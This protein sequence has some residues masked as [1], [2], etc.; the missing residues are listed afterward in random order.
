MTILSGRE[1]R[2][3]SFGRVALK[4]LTVDMTVG[5]TKLL[6]GKAFLIFFYSFTVSVVLWKSNCK[7]GGFSFFSHLLFC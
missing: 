6:G 2:C 5:T 1:F 3:R 7:A 4:R